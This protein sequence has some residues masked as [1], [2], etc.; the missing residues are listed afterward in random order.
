MAA[1]LDDPCRFLKGVGPRR[2][3]T[4]QR[5][6]ILCAEDVLLHAPR[7]HFDRSN[8]VPIRDLAPDT[9]TCVRVR[10]ESVHAG[11]RW[12]GRTRLHATVSDDTGRMRVVWYA[13]WVR[14]VLQPGNEL[15]LAG[16]VFASGARLEMRQ[17]EFERIEPGS[18]DLLHA[19]RIVPFYPLTRGISQK[20]M[21]GLVHRTLATHADLVEEVLP[22]AVL[23]GRPSRREAFRALH[24][25]NSADEGRRALER[26]KFEELFLLQ[27]VLARRR[28][29]ARRSDASL[30][31]QRAKSLHERYVKSLPF[32]L[33]RA[34]E[35][36]LEEILVDLESGRCMQRLVQGDV[37]SGKTVL[38][39]AALLA[40]CGNGC[41]GA[42]MAPTEALALQ[43]AER[44]LAVCMELGVRMEVLVG[45]RSENDKRRIRA[46]L[47]GG[48][49]DLVIGT[50]A[51]I[52]DDVRWLRPGLVVIDEQQRF[53]V[54]QRARLQR[55]G[56]RDDRLRPHVLVLSATPIPRSLALTLFGDLDVSRL[57]E[58]PPGRQRVATHLVP[59]GRRADML[60]FVR[61][62]LE[63][64]RQAF[65]VLPLIEESDKMDLRAAT[66]EYER[67]QR[68]PLAGARMGLLHGRLPA[69]EKESLR[70]AFGSGALQLL[71]TTTVVEVGLDVA[72]ASL[73]IIHHPERF[74]LSQLHQLR[75]RVGRA[76]G[77]AWCLLLLERTQSNEAVERLR[78]FA[79]TDDGFAI[80]ELDLK[81]R[82]P[83]DFVGTRQ[84]G[85]PTLRFANL[86]EDL[87]L[88]E[89]AR[90]QAFALIRD[91][92]E[93]SRPENA[94]MRQHLE[95]RYRER[96]V[97]AEI[98]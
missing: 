62:Q 1:R 76:G 92:P 67:L 10:L 30:R 65:M 87:T 64:G 77:E 17:P 84:H 22:P 93:L 36:V 60:A 72:R 39:V 78:E 81:L 88:L 13:A 44:S 26:F 23:A 24:F 85:L 32:T 66:E 94:A 61:R 27:A 38:A 29:R 91:D 98:G 68:G 45:S 21:R 31:L 41:Q 53:G 51:L 79:G 35:R 83:G 74:G 63:A 69:S 80:A 57:D 55:A 3:E 95:T 6:G 15:V 52:Q 75:G 70:Q 47:E 11:R 50:H 33:T 42:L 12:R 37:G 16:R 34:Q 25:P 9:E 49:L 46:L 19:A 59:P 8:L 96:E 58:K 56:G 40:A 54:L 28:T 43:H 90:R 48:N 4:L 89:S 82:G 5:L 20:W 18:Q 86:S 7:Q 2:A 14:D 97:A 71:V 73:M